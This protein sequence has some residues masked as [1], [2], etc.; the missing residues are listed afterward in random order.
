ME[1]TGLAWGRGVTGRFVRVSLTLPSL[2]PDTAA[3]P[4]HSPPQE[5]HWL[6]LSTLPPSKYICTDLPSIRRVP[7]SW[8]K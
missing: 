8:G 4:P 2:P 3:A 7:C 1:G 6:A 5:T